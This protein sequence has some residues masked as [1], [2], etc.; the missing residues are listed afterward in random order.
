MRRGTCTAQSSPSTGAGSPADRAPAAVAVGLR[1][2]QGELVR[3]LSPLADRL[4]V[5][6]R[7]NPGSSPGASHPRSP[8]RRRR[9]SCE[10]GPLR[11]RSRRYPSAQTAGLV[12]QDVVQG[13]PAGDPALAH[14]FLLPGLSAATASGHSDPPESRSAVRRRLDLGVTVG[15]Q[16]G[17]P[18]LVDLQKLPPYVE[19]PAR[20]RAHPDGQSRLPAAPLTV[21]LSRNAVPS[22][23]P[24]TGVTDANGP[25]IH[26]RKALKTKD[27]L[28]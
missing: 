26:R 16:L 7:T 22:R 27:Q 9:G 28:R 13:L 8:H 20:A 15:R 24:S 12:S 23:S 5:R 18:P 14:P 2:P 6:P 10:R 11:P 1:R 3:P 25:R 17:F 4:D 21:P 19:L